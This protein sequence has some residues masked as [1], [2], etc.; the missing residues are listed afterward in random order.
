MY[1]GVRRRSS[2]ESSDTKGNEA[3]SEQEVQD[4]TTVRTASA[5]SEEIFDHKLTRIEK[6][7]AGPAVH[8]G[9]GTGVGGL[10]GAGS[11]N[12]AESYCRERPAF[13]CGLLASC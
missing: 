7:I 8:Y 3:K 5:I 12:S 1:G 13:R 9:L 6:K 4:D 11:R 10:Y 2:S